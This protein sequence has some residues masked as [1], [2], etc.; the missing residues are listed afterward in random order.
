[1]KNVHRTSRDV[2]VLC[3]TREM[4]TVLYFQRGEGA[5]MKSGTVLYTKASKNI[6]P[7]WKQD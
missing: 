7:A 3:A 2:C 4:S 1:V 6:Q 5:W